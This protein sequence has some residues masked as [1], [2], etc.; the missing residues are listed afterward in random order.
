MERKNVTFS[1]EKVFIHQFKTEHYW[2]CSEINIIINKTQ[3]E[4][5]VGKGGKGKSLKHSGCYCV[6]E[7]DFLLMAQCCPLQST[8]IGMM[9]WASLKH[10]FPKLPLLVCCVVRI[11]VYSQ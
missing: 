9:T 3:S 4:R 5:N 2:E 10:H 1:F 7:I 8:S 6:E 11:I